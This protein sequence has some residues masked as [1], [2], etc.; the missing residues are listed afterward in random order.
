MAY[1]RRGTVRLT[2]RVLRPISSCCF[3]QKMTPP[4]WLGGQAI[5]PLPYLNDS[6]TWTGALKHC[7]D[8]NSTLVHIT[9]SAVQNNVSRLLNNQSFSSGVWVGLERSYLTCNGPWFWV[10]GP[11]V[12]YSQWSV[13]FTETPPQH[14]CGKVFR[15]DD[16]AVLWQDGRCEEKLPFICQQEKRNIGTDVPYMV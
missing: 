11:Q 4:R 8:E 2:C 16:N 7:I 14:H 15:S 13:N 3:S 1:R 9:N 5:A 12:T 6:K 10:G